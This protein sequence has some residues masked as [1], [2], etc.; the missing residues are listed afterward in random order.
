MAQQTKTEGKNGANKR[1]TFRKQSIYAGAHVVVLCYSEH[2]V[3][4][5]QR[6]APHRQ[7]VGAWS[8]N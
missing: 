7:A 4:P 3:K 2:K 8:E 5:R 6:N 1:C